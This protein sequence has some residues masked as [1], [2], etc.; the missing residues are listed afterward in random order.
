M[1]TILI[2]EDTPDLLEL[3]TRLVQGMGHEPIT[4]NCGD[5]AGDIIAARS[6]D[7]DLALLDFQLPGRDGLAIA[8]DLA[9]ITIPWAMITGDNKQAVKDRAHD[10]GALEVVHKP[11]RQ[12]ALRERI[13]VW[14]AMTDHAKRSAERIEKARRINF[15]VGVLSERYRLQ[16]PHAYSELRKLSRVRNTS[17]LACATEI[18]AAQ[19]LLCGVRQVWY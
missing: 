1:A 19:N 13:S 4:A 11:V 2:V 7:I 15:A 8:Q 6:T 10:L 17:M 18:A 5:T 9:A 12:A 14:L 16:E 3:W